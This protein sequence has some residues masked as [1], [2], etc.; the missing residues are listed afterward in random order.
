[1]NTYME[2]YFKVKD[3]ELEYKELYKKYTR[4]AAGADWLQE[5]YSTIILGPSEDFGGDDIT[6]PI[7]LADLKSYIEDDGQLL[8]FHDTLTK[9][10]D[11]GT[12]T[13]TATLRSYFGMDRYHFNDPV[14]TDA[15]QNYVKY[16]T[17]QDSDKYFMTNLST[18]KDESRYTSWLSDMKKVFGSTPSKYLT[19]VRLYRCGKCQW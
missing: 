16:T 12:S 19:S 3:K 18:T 14:T 6:S 11:K 1:M 15:S 17:T 8:L 4:Y 7:A 9:F 13:L 10:S 2:E 5:S